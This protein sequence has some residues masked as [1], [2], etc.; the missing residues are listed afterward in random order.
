MQATIPASDK[1]KSLALTIVIYALFLLLLFF[2]RFWPPSNVTEML[3]AGGGGGG[4]VTVNF[5]DTEFGSGN[6]FQSKA[7]EVKNNVK[8]AVSKPVE[9]E[10][11]IIAQENSTDK[12][13]VVIAQKPITKKPKVE[14]I[15]KEE[16]KQ[17]V[18]EEKSKV[19]KNTNDALAN[20][21]KGGNKGGDGNTSSQGNQ[22]SSNGSISSGAYGMGGT[23]GGT[24]GGG[25]TGNGTGSGAGSGS[26]S[27]GGSGSGSGGGVGYSLGDRKALSKPAPKYVCNEE[28]KVVVEVSVDRNGNTISV[29]P[30]VKGTTNT[31]SC[32]L[33]QA[34]IAAMNTKWQAS[35]DAPERQVGK[36]VY[37][38]SLN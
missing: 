12:N 11:K 17:P 13:D 7:L 36:I 1:R 23:G 18:V 5:G 31:A 16:I 30:G 19:N 8:Q 9:P 6:N 27:G 35:D 28:G 22:G 15:K 29:I 4:G 37:S 38:F 20:I 32:L 3:L 21:L 34:K 2:I 26:G 25:G 10:E 24:G 14:V 33:N